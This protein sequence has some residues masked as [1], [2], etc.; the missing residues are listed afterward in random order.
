M[1]GQRMLKRVCYYVMEGTRYIF[2]D[3]RNKKKLLDF[4]REVRDAEEW[5]IYAFCVTDDRAY[6]IIE[7]PQENSVLAGMRGVMESYLHMFRAAPW[8]PRGF[9]AHLTGRVETRLGSLQEIAA[10]SRWIHRLPV[11]MGYARALR[12]YWWS[13]YITYLGIY[14]WRM[15]D[16]RVVLLYFSIDTDEARQLLR[17]YHMQER[18][19]RGGCGEPLDGME[20]QVS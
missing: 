5:S 11:E 20:R 7:A 13:S 14:D 2:A 16:E 3:E 6:F 8:N 9:A 12:D 17:D 10:Y 1:S 19:E 18:T 15:V 4:V